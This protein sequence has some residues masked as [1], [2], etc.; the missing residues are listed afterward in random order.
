MTRYNLCIPYALKDELKNS[1]KLKFD[2]DKKIWY[3]LSNDDLPED[4]KKYKQM[5]VDIDYDDKDIM[6]KKYKS[7]RFDFL[8][9]SWYCSLEDFLKMGN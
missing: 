6:K 2:M 8:E 3:I 1:H 5:F 4:L 7:L 9:K